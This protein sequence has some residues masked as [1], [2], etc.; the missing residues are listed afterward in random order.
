[1]WK[2]NHF[3]PAEMWPPSSTWGSWFDGG[4]GWA[5][6]SQVQ[7]GETLVLTENSGFQLG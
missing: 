1:M 7:L 2:G 6:I 5:V 3:I 4:G